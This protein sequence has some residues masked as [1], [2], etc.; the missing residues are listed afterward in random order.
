MKIC[1]VLEGCYP[2][3]YGG[4]SAWMHQYIQKM[5]DHEFILWVIGADSSKQGQFVYEI[6]KNVVQV[7]EVFLN[8]A[9]KIKEQKGRMLHRYSAEETETLGKLMNGGRPDWNLLFQL[10][11]KERLNPMSYLKS[12][13]FLETLIDICQKQYP[14]IAFADAFH[15][16]RSMLLP[17]LYLMGTEVPQADV[18]HAVATGYGGLLASMGSWLYDKPL[19]LTEH[20]IYTREREEEL[21]RA[22]WVLPAFKKQWIRFFYVLSDLIY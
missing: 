8:D 1:L 14:Y 18:Y 5:K 7:Y 10:Y 20:G 21:I 22:K 11:Q 19:L 9:L 16:I 15:T 17:V 3:V 2:Y 13:H 4:V 6:P 12:S